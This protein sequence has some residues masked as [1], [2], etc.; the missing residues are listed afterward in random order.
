MPPPSN[1]VCGG[2]TTAAG[3][4]QLALNGTHPVL[5]KEHI[6]Q[7]A[8][9]RRGS[10]A[11]GM[12]QEAESTWVVRQAVTVEGSVFHADRHRIVVFEIR[13]RCCPRRGTPQPHEE[14]Q[15]IK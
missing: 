5:T 7:Q 14:D 12:A 6:E 15:E 8:V 13:V 1:L 9:P 3:K 10:R 2:D 4:G 11:Q